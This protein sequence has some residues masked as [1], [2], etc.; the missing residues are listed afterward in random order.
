MVRRV[1]R[2]GSH[3]ARCSPDSRGRLKSRDRNA[4]NVKGSAGD[5]CGRIGERVTGFCA[6]VPV[7]AA[8][9]GVGHDCESGD[10]MGKRVFRFLTA[11]AVLISVSGAAQPAALGDQPGA[12]DVTVEGE[13]QRLVVE[14]L[15]GEAIEASAVVTTSGDVI[16]VQSDDVSDVP[17]G[18]EVELQIPAADALAD[19]EDVLDSDGGASVLSLQVLAL[20]EPTEASLP[21]L[22]GPGTDGVAL[23]AG[24]TA[25]TVH[26]ATGRISGQ[27]APSVTT[28]QLASSLT[29]QVAPYWSDSTTGDVLFS[30]GTETTAGTYADWG[31]TS[32]CTVGQ[33]LG[34]LA[35]ANDQTGVGPTVGQGKHVVLYTPRL[36]VCGFS[37]AAHVGDG[38]T[39]WLNGPNGA[40]PSWSVMAHELGHTL[41]LGHSNTRIDCGAADGA[42]CSEGEYGDA[43]DVMGWSVGGPGPLNGAQLDRLGLLTSASAVVATGPLSVALAPVGG[44]SGVRFLVFETGGA[45]YYVEYRAAVG[46][47]A[48]LATTRAGCPYGLTACGSWV[49]YTPG[50]VIHRIDGVPGEGAATHLLDAGVGD[51]A[52]TS[53]DPRFVLT[54]GRSFRTANGAFIVTVDSLSSGGAIVRLIDGGTW[55]P[56]GSPRGQF[57]SVAGVLGGVRVRGWALD[58]DTSASTYVWV[59]VA[60]A[61][62]PVLA[63]VER[64]DVAA[65]YPAYGSAHGFD[66]VIPAAA[67][68]R[69]VCVTAVDVGSGSNVS[70]GCRSVVVPNASPRGQF[71]SVGGVQGGVRVRGWALDPETSASTYVWVSVAG[72]GGPVRASVMR[73]DIAAAFPTLGGNHG[74]DAVVPAAAGIRKVCLTAVNVGSG[75]NVSL[76]CRSVVVPAG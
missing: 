50:V 60:G 14:P 3:C 32:T 23:L 36:S 70:L 47:D 26:M 39:A 8:P 38:G 61:G 20:P 64:P 17:S 30:S 52:H 44:G 1:T 63:G 4:E 76:G 34:V 59:S 6:R 22:S 33:V 55:L 5:P 35:W 62:G 24:P 2:S 56:G 15:V 41:G 65:V 72:G 45:S 66:A 68:T 12:G 10:I 37:G 71:E 7:A 75:S 40:V 48:D 43:Y 21:D 54:A 13:L 16:R 51:V 57:E 29:A 74:F 11:L 9:S 42:S 31:L 67:G 25:R 28:A 27:A 49:R 53:S 46:R 69:Q 18:A 58:P 73:S 19:D